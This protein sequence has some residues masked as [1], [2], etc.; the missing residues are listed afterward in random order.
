MATSHTL[1]VDPD[2]AAQLQFLARQQV[3]SPEMLV[4]EAIDAYLARTNDIDD[5]TAAAHDAISDKYEGPFLTDEEL[6]AEAEASFRQYKQT[7]LHV[8][9]DEV[10]QWLDRLR[11][12]PNAKPPICHT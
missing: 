9:N 3:R 10:G 7:G 12:D 6:F 11:T 5:E 4:R 2:Q 8:T 1:T